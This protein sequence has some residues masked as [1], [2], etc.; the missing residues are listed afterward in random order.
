MKRENLPHSSSCLTQSSLS[1]PTAHQHSDDTN[2]FECVF[3]FR[4]PSN[5]GAQARKHN[6]LA[7]ALIICQRHTYDIDHTHQH[8]VLIHLLDALQQRLQGDQHAT[9]VGQVICVYTQGVR[10]CI[11]VMND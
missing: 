2:Y 6:L 5:A 9:H 8:P 7:D 11:F 10:V 1:S 4:H 3:L